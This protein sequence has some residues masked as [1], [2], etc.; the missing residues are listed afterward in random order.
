MTM[1]IVT[2]RITGKLYGNEVKTLLMYDPMEPFSIKVMFSEE[3]VWEIS[4]EVLWQ[5]LRQNSAG[6]LNVTLDSDGNN[7]TMHLTSEEGSVMVTFPHS[8]LTTFIHNTFEQVPE[9]REDE[10]LY[11]DDEIDKFWESV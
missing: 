9:N 7:V 3:N 1:K 8:E 10:F 11:L 6:Y 5:C 4:R 2:H